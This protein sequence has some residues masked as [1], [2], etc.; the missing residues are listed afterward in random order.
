M[1]GKLCIPPDISC[2]QVI[3]GVS[4]LLY[5]AII[6]LGH[7]YLLFTTTSFIITLTLLVYNTFCIQDKLGCTMYLLTEYFVRPYLL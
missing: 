1:Q 6:Q 3:Y 7:N 5:I 2:L 4:L